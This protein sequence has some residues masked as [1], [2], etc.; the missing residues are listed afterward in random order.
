MSVNLG[1]SEVRIFFIFIRDHLDC[2]PFIVNV[3]NKY[4]DILE[5]DRFLPHGCTF[6]MKKLFCTYISIVYCKTDC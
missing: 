1:C 2:S 3:N 4:R 5:L 6:G